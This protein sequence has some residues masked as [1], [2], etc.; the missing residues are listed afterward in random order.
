VVWFAGGPG[1]SAVD[2]ISWMYP[3]TASLNTHRDMVF[4]EQRGTGESNP[5][6]CPAFP[7]LAGPAALRRAVQSCLASLHGDLRYYTTAMFTDD[8][9]QVLTAL[10]YSTANL[11]GLSYGT[12]A[13]QVFQIRHPGQVRTMTLLSGTPLTI[14]LFARAPANTQLA[15]EYVFAQCAS[16]PACHQAFPH[17]AADWSALWAA[18]GKSP[19]VVPAAQSPTGQAERLDQN[20]L[21]YLAY[22]A[23][24]NGNLSPIPLEVHLLAAATDKTA[25]MLA[26]QHAFP[27]SQPTGNSANQMMYYAIDCGE[28]W[29]SNR[30]EALAGQRASF[31]YANDLGYAQYLQSVCALIPTST[32]AIGHVRVSASN[33]PVLAFNGAADP[34]E[35]PRNM[36]GAGQLWPDSLAVTV[37]GMGHDDLSGLGSCGMELDQEFIDHAST[38][39]LN[40]TCMAATPAPVFDVTLP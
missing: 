20:E 33:V 27:Q 14:P 9:S 37:P 32:A 36:A 13:E 39:G 5:L 22:Q 21:A 18:L 8:V 11:I 2:S 23:L 19:V 25:A 3:L 26:L 38:A 24:Y 40:A 1:N 4:I 6:N 35:Q 15:L 17:L 7:S 30:P 10:H 28:P 16:Q 31:A 29:E 34:I 12:T